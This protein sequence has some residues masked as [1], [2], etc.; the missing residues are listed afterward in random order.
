MIEDLFYNRIQ[1][2][3]YESY[4]SYIIWHK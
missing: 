2:S 4:V 3:F 1:I